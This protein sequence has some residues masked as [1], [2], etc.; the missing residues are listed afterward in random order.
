MKGLTLASFSDITLA[1]FQHLVSMA[2]I[3]GSWVEE[4]LDPL[5][6]N[7]RT[8]VWLVIGTLST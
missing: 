1:R 2:G 5:R 4:G 8:I 7:V 6:E 3:D